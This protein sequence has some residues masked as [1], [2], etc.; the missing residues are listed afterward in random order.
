MNTHPPSAVPGACKFLLLSVSLCCTPAVW[1]RATAD[2]HVTTATSPAGMQ[3]RWQW[4]IAQPREPGLPANPGQAGEAI[5]WPAAF[6]F[7]DILP[8]NEKVLPGRWLSL[9]PRDTR[10]LPAF[11]DTVDKRLVSLAPAAHTLCNGVT[12][13]SVVKALH[14][15]SSGLSVQV[16]YTMKF[17]NGAS[18]SSGGAGELD[19]DGQW[20][21][22]PFGTTRPRPDGCPLTDE[23]LPPRPAVAMDVPPASTG[24][25]KLKLV[26]VLGQPA[27]RDV[28]TG[29]WVTPQPPQD[30][31]LAQW[32]THRLSPFDKPAIGG[33]GVIDASG[34]LVVPMIFGS[35]TDV[36]PNAT[37]NA[38]LVR[39]G[40]L[41][42]QESPL[43][44][45]PSAKS[46]ARGFRPAQ[47]SNGKWGYV[48]P[49]GKW[50][51]QP[52]YASAQPFVNGYAVVSGAM[53]AGWCPEGMSAD[54]WQQ[55]LVRS[56]MRLGNA[57]VIGVAPPLPENPED[58][59]AARARRLYGGR[60]V[61]DDEGR[62]LLPVVTP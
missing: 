33:F 34:R 7:S 48:G 17:A 49:R 4:Q 36:R 41:L 26:E 47:G 35:L 46:F 25:P 18:R 14:A 22:Y 39:E 8:V 53:P 60:A 24:A 43:L 28:L 62:W 16:R 59:D 23:V 11:Y 13:D 31:V 37:L 19:A 1:A 42:H 30:P 61:M 9:T 5:P 54:L 56:I 51:V 15:R 10:W 38:E 58:A 52:Q 3:Q 50:V 6:A 44:R 2:P 57:W 20:S 45:V 55:P 12:I 40:E 21:Q 29:R 27:L 32:Q